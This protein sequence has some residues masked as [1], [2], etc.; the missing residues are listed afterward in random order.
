MVD[1]SVAAGLADYPFK[2]L[3]DSRHGKVYHCQFVVTDDDLPS[4]LNL[5]AAH[6]NDA[7]C[8]TRHAARPEFGGSVIELATNSIALLRAL[9]AMRLRPPAPWLAFPEID[10]AAYGSLQGSLEYWWTWLWMPYWHN[11]TPD[12]RE[13]LLAQASDDWREF[14]EFHV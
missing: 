2:E 11:A 4:L 7:G 6:A 8:I 13:Q 10:A 1:L 14:F 5:L 9:D 3:V 12:E